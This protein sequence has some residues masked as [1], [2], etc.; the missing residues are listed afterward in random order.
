M[1]L[2]LFL[3]LHGTKHRWGQLKLVCDLAEV[4][5][6]HPQ[7]NWNQV[8]R[9]AAELDCERM[10]GIGLSLASALLDARLPD[11]V[12]QAMESDT[13]IQAMAEEAV[14]S[15]LRFGARTPGRDNLF[16][17]RALE[18]ASTRIRYFLHLALVPTVEDLHSRSLPPPL[19]FLHYPLHILGVLAKALRLISGRWA[20]RSDTEDRTT[21]R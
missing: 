15:L 3:C 10:L 19:S 16:H 14:D 11:G 6:S 18:P 8:R 17:A 20:N 13:T 9:E 12:V 7:L 21:A 2:L 1:D 4:I 5:R